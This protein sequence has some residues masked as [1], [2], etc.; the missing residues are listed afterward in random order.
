MAT[1][2]ADHSTIHVILN[3][4]SSVEVG[5]IFG[6]FISIIKDKYHLKTYSR[7]LHAVS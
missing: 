2:Q 5:D 1:F 3:E 7:T 6:L 4:L